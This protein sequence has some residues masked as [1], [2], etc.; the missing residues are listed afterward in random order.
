MPTFGH[1]FYG[2]CLLLPLIYFTKGKFSYKVAFIFLL[3]NLY[4]PDMVALFVVTPFHSI[5]GY[6]ILAIPFSL[7]MSYASRFSLIRSE[8]RFPLKFEDGGIREVNWKNAYLLTAAGGISHF[9]IDQFFHWELS[10]NLWSSLGFDISIPHSDFLALSGVPYHYL[11]PFLFIGNAIVMT[12]LILSFYFFKKGF[13]DTAKFF[14]ITTA[15]ALAAMLFLS[16]LTFFGEREYAVLIQASLYILLPLFLL[17][18]VAR[19]VQDHPKTVEDIPKIKRS[20]LLKV[21]AGVS[22][23]FGLFITIYALLALL[24]PEFV[25]S[26]LGDTNPEIITSVIVFGSIYLTVALALLLGSIGVL[27]R[28][29]FFRYLT[30][31][32]ALYFI[33]FGFPIAIALFLCERDVKKIFKQKR[34]E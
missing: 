12:A 33:I 30:I 34:F 8:G 14:L 29:N 22:A 18:Y 13:K 7:V 16:P 4:G 17:L 3:N 24:M 31:A 6:L 11:S 10:M 20:T 21:N 27:F 32:A 15:L 25:A 5:L 1:V 19:D 28:V 23:L 2:L 9:F 26:L